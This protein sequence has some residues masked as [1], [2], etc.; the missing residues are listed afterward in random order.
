M[1]GDILSVLASDDYH[2]MQQCLYTMRRL[3]QYEGKINLPR[4]ELRAV[5][6]NLFTTR[7]AA[8]IAKLTAIQP[9]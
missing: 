5:L 2:A 7:S 6:S 1:L 4:T 8:C 3:G 9:T